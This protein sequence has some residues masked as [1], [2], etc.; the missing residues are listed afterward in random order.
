MFTRRRVF[1]AK[2]HT[3][4]VWYRDAPAIQL[5]QPG[6]WPI[7]AVGI[8]IALWVAGQVFSHFD[9]EYV[10]ARWSCPA[11][12]NVRTGPGVHYPVKFA[13]ECAHWVEISKGTEES[14]SRHGRMSIWVEVRTAEGH[15]WANRRLLNY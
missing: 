8:F 11:Q 1:V 4:G 2:A 10:S 15:G 12:A 13:A 3:G 6:G 5:Q 9:A 7:I 14:V